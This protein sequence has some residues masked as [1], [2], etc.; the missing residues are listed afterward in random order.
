MSAFLAMGG[1]AAYV[2]AAYAFAAAVLVGVLG[3]SLIS[4]RSREASLRALAERRAPRGK[5]QGASQALNRTL[6]SGRS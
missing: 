4:L 5:G 2:W 1:Y 3:V 6:E